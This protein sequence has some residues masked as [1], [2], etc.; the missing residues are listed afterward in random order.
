ME[1][2]YLLA[3]QLM[4]HEPRPVITVGEC[5]LCGEECAIGTVCLACQERPPRKKGHTYKIKWK[6]GRGRDYDQFRTYE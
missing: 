5:R 3:I 6:P 2:W 4:N 1:C